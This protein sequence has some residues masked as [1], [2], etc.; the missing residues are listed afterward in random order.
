VSFVARAYWAES[1]V[2][3]MN[4]QQASPKRAVIIAG[5]FLVLAAGALGAAFFYFDGVSV[6]S[7]LIAQVSSG[8]LFSSSASGTPQPGV[9]TESSASASSTATTLTLPS[10]MPDE[11]ALRIWQE[12]VDSQPMIRRLVDGEVTRMVITNVETSGDT[13]TLTVRVTLGDG[14]T[15]DGEIVMRKF[16][17]TW[18]IATATSEDRA[19][20]DEMS[21]L[22]SL[23]EVDIPL[24]NTIIAE[25]EKS[26]A[27]TAEYADGVVATVDIAKPQA[28]ANTVRIPV[29]MVEEHESSAAD[30]VT[31]KH[32]AD[33]TDLWFIARFNKTGSAPPEK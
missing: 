3:A 30:L 25:Q 22:P 18:F 20:S 24:L 23:D 32:V 15:V 4:E 6:F 5:L 31:I 12:Q 26:K 28:G 14:A 17:D 2:V 8:S 9:S 16:D 1:A 33:G 21:P 11:F 10:G 13:S 7:D 27:I 19:K 29:T